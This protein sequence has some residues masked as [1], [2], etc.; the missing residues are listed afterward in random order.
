[1]FP[2]SEDTSATSHAQSIAG[3]SRGTGGIYFVVERVE[4]AN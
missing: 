4:G 1:M 2:R 3:D